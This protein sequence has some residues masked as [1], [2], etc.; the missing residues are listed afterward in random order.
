[1]SDSY[2]VDDEMIDFGNPN[3]Y[4]FGHQSNIPISKTHDN[5]NLPSKE[6]ASSPCLL[7]TSSLPG[8]PPHQSNMSDS[9]MI[10]IP[11]E[12]TVPSILNSD[13]IDN[14]NEIRDGSS[15]LYT[16]L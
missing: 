4:F 16:L 2:P 8:S 9:E 10:M 12:E 5:E 3:W 7:P 15:I 6:Y 14:E 11:S 13:T 1:M